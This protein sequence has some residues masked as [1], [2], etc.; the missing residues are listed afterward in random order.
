MAQRKIPCMPWKES[1]I[2]GE[3]I[4]FIADK[5]TASWPASMPLYL[6]WL[7]AQKIFFRQIETLRAAF[8]RPPA[9]ISTLPR[10]AGCAPIKTERLFQQHYLSWGS[11]RQATVKFIEHVLRACSDIREIPEVAADIS[12]E[13][14]WIR[15]WMQVVEI[16]IIKRWFSRRRWEILNL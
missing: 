13:P 8:C 15:L 6:A 9:R 10:M 7:N 5:L 16:T 12:P 2:V 1:R 4:K 3:R 14:K 11:L